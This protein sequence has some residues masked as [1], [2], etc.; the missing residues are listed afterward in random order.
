MMSMLDGSHLEPDPVQVE[1]TNLVHVF[2]L[3]VRQL[4]DA[5]PSGKTLD[6]EH[7]PLR[8]FFLVLEHILKHGLRPRKGL[9]G[10]K[11]EIWDI[12]QQVERLC[13]TAQD[14]TT[15]IR[16]L[17]TV[18]SA[19]GRARAWLRLALMQKKL[20]DYLWI[21]LENRETVLLPFFRPGALL[22]S[23]EGAVIAGLLVG[24][25]CLD[26]NLCLKEEDLDKAEG[27]ID[28]S[29]YFRDTDQ[30]NP[31][32]EDSSNAEN[33]NVAAVLDQK[34]YL[35][36]LN[37]HLTATV[38]N[39]Q[40]RLESVTAT[41]ALTIEDLEVTRSQVKRLQEEIEELKGNKDG[42]KV[43][44]DF[45]MVQTEPEKETINSHDDA[46]AQLKL[47]LAEEKNRRLDLERELE[48][49]AGL[50]AEAEMALKLVERDTHEKQDSLM[51]L[52]KQLDDVKKINLELYK[53]LQ[54]TQE[55]LI[56]SAEKLK[57]LEEFRRKGTETIQ[58]LEKEL[59]QTKAELFRVSNENDGNKERNVQLDTEEK[60][61]KL[62]LDKERGKRISLEKTV[63]T[64]QCRAAA[65][66]QLYEKHTMTAA[67]LAETQRLATE[68]EKAL[69]E[70][71]DKL[72][73][74]NLEA[75]ALR[76]KTAIGIQW[77]DDD[78][79]THCKLCNKPFN[80]TRRKHH[81][82]KC[83]EIF[84]GDCSSKQRILPEL[85][86]KPVRVCDTCFSSDSETSDR[87]L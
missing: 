64:L 14:L 59:S 57:S 66:S 80:L 39:L 85:P 52:R 17:P 75:D 27:V 56:I 50:R 65:F 1:R 18:R 3:V 6:E 83:G 73:A 8:H 7:A 38:Q 41:H 44:D 71:G 55:T 21:L 68:R 11:R 72:G 69:E 29:L 2:R 53:Q 60:S 67:A 43:A 30:E 51:A 78:L 20:A 49:Q 5:F 46:I 81:C 36:E 16:D 79:V 9:L 26:V 82:R 31:V 61:L 24:L 70:I 23:E 74:A 4:L 25:N 42:N 22:L 33:T 62:E 35:E 45:V 58:F 19:E 34:N 32:N 47:L 86:H 13:P 12:L 87:T 48:I 28:F 76:E 84:C 10:P 63:E 37:R 40:T 54:S 15:S 77:I